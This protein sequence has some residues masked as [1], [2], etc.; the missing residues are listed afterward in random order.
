MATVD[1]IDL[2]TWHALRN[3]VRTALADRNVVVSD[4]DTDLIARF[5]FEEVERRGLRIVPLKPTRRMQEAIDRALDM[6]KRLSVAWVRNRT[7]H[8]WRYTAALEAAPDWRRGYE[9]DRA[10][11]SIDQKE[12]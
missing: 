8:R 7:K 9:A 10:A 1:Q 12:I 4:N 5:V 6:G 2:S 3:S 11:R